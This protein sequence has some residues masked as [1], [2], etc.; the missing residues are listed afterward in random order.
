[1][2]NVPSLIRAL[3]GETLKTPPVWFMRQAG[4]SLP[5]YRA[6]REQAKD[7]VAFC[8]DPAMAAEAT[9]QPMRRFPLDAA[10][11]FADIL[12]IPLALGQAVWFEPGEGPR[13]GEMPSFKSME[14]RIDT[15]AAKLSAVGETL[16]RVRSGLEP[17]R[18]L[19]GFAG[20]PWT[21]ATYMLERKGGD[22]AKVR[23]L[24]YAEIE[25]VDRLIDVL[26]EA[27]ARY[28][29][30]QAKAGAQALKLF[31]SWAEHLPEDQ[32]QRL[33]VGPHARIVERVRQLGV[34]VPIIGFPRG[35]GSLVEVYADAVEVQGVALDETASAAFGRR[36]QQKRT[37]QGALDNLLLR[38]GGSQ[39]DRRIDELKAA[40]GG[41]P[42]IF[43]LGHGVMPDTPIAHI[44]QALARIKAA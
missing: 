27:T 12:L 25:Q 4:R 40:W 14:G 34:T 28:L 11:V 13:L 15:V 20:A 7:F 16:Q 17:E 22:R 32:F 38:A 41:G 2:T 33:V 10:I 42:W 37:I 6:L 39:L 24:A 5:E 29:V 9:L 31:E 23:G 8:L 3:S 36:I 35:A 43:N 30:M 19:I 26:V 44:E 21:V 18:A 1:M